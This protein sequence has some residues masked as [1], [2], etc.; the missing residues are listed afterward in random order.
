VEAYRKAIAAGA[1]RFGIHMMTGS[2]VMEQNYWKE[3]VAILFDT[4]LTLKKELDIE[5]EFMNIGGGLGIPY[6][7]DQPTVN[8]ESISKMIRTFF[9]QAMATHNLVRTTSNTLQCIF[10]K[11]KLILSDRHPSLNYAWKMVVT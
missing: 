6:Y 2:C 10:M 1:K 3:T 9:D 8:I 7:P 5:F 11:L 4:I